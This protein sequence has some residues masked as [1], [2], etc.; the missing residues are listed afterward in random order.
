MQKPSEERLAKAAYNWLRISPIVT[1]TTLFI[2]TNMG[3][4]SLFCNGNL[5]ACSYGN[6]SLINIGI[7]VLVSALWHLLLLQYV[8]NKDSEFVRK[9][10][11]QALTYAGIRTAIAFTGVLLDYFA[12]SNG[13]LDCVTIIILLIFWVAQTNAG[14]EKIKKE[15]EEDPTISREL[16][17][18]TE[19]TSAIASSNEISNVSNEKVEVIGET[20]MENNSAQNDPS[21]QENLDNI[22]SGLRSAIDSDRRHAIENLREINYSSPAIRLQLEKMSLQDSNSIVRKEALRALSLPSNQ[23][24]QKHNHANKLN[25]QIRQTLLQ[26]IKAWVKDGLLAQENADVIQSRYDFDITSTP[27]PQ[28]T[29]ASKPVAVSKPVPLVQTAAQPA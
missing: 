24:V 13:S 29:P 1:I 2:V 5:Y 20:V 6:E 16:T 27:Q 14:L 19:N 18:Q 8:N 25:L 12:G 15:L 21:Q 10:G 26:E 4:N 7:G 9:H 22:L 28:V 17:Q 23:A 11:K 3:L